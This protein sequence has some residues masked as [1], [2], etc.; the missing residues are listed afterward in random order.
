MAAFFILVLKCWLAVGVVGSSGGKAC[1]QHAVPGW[2]ELGA[3]QLFCSMPGWQACVPSVVR[4]ELQ[5]AWLWCILRIICCFSRW[6]E[7]LQ[8]ILGSPRSRELLFWTF[9][10]L[11]QTAGLEFRFVMWKWAKISFSYWQK[12]SDLAALG[13]H[14]ILHFRWYTKRARQLCPWCS[15]CTSFTC[16]WELAFL[17]PAHLL[18]HLHRPPRCIPTSQSAWWRH[19]VCLHVLW[20]CVVSFTGFVWTPERKALLSQPPGQVVWLSRMEP[21]ST[22]G[23]GASRAQ[24]EWTQGF[25]PL[26]WEGFKR[27]GHGLQRHPPRPPTPQDILERLRKLWNLLLLRM[28]GLERW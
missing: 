5:T 19:Q 3:A 26:G 24:R 9:I 4:C 2:P 20:L 25:L 16:V 11:Y 6:C 14:G 7:V 13:F 22:W 27:E 12:S 28:L 17:F 18:L 21:W 10:V 15:C 8:T 1:V 23:R